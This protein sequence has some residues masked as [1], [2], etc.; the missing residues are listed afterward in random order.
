MLTQHVHMCRQRLSG[1]FR[2]A[3]D[4]LKEEGNLELAQ[5]MYKLCVEMC[6]FNGNAVCRR[7][8]INLQVLPGHP[9]LH[10]M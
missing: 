4:S 10:F 8:H 5:E 2:L 6:P 7:A 1:G 9:L 3:G